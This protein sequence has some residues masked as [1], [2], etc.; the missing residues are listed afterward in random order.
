MQIPIENIYYLLCYAWAKLKER[1]LVRVDPTETTTLE[2]LFAKVLIGGANHLIKKGFDRGYVQYAEDTRRICGRI[3]ISSTLRRNLLSKGIVHCEFDDLSYNV[4]HNQILKSTMKNLTRAEDLD[5]KLRE[6]LIA[7]YHRLQEV[8]EIAI[9]GR[10][11][12]LVQLNR[13]NYFYDFLI[14]VCELI[15]MHLLPS[16]HPGKWRFVDFLQDEELMPHL[17]EEFVRNFYKIEGRGLK[18]GRENIHWRLTSA[19]AEATRL[20][21]DM[22]T[23]ISINSGGGGLII[24]CKYMAG[25]VPNRYGTPKLRSD[26]LY[27]LTAYLAN[28]PDVEP[29]RAVRA[30]L[31]YPTVDHDFNKEYSD[32]KGTKISVRTINLNQGWKQIHTELLA[33]V[34]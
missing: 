32:P 24:E 20:L 22:Q 31:L 29:K 14:R 33:M 12:R 28:L 2:N 13:N 11:F 23:D 18:V 6:E 15:S 7:C 8:D 9:S 19:S 3:C 21:P 16:T 1:D 5:P 26:H 4:L 17:F 34:A 30:I 25:I 27:Q 10:I